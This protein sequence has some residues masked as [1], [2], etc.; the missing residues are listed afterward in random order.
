MVALTHSFHGRTL[1]GMSL[2]GKASYY[3]QNF[4]PFAPEVY[5]APA[6]YPYRGVSDGLALEGLEELFRTQVDPE[7]VATLILEPVSGE[8]GLSPFLPSTCG[9]CARSPRPTVFCWWRTRSSPASAAR[10]RCG[11]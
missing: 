10:G 2:T 8:G 3:K 1:L 5:H 7:R 6:P 4:G 9:R 11:P